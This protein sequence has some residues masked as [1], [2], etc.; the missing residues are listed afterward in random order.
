MKCKLVGY[1]QYTIPKNKE[2]GEV[3]ECLTLHLVRKPSLRENGA[4]GNITVATT[5]YDEAVKKLPALEVGADYEC[6]INSYKGKN[7]LN[8]ITKL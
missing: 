8:D 5:V 2:T 3:A 4:V 6:D 7:Y 1:N